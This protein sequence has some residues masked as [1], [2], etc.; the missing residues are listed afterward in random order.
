M[1][2]QEA[3]L[4]IIYALDT[5]VRLEKKEVR[6]RKWQSKKGG[7]NIHF[8]LLIFL[9]SNIWFVW[10]GHQKYSFNGKVGFLFLFF[11]FFIYV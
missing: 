4:K 9:Y 8:V 5:K 10:Y 6:D 1:Q 7:W 11:I 2:T 3:D